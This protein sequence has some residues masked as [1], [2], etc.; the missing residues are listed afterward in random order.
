MSFCFM[1]FK[2]SF[3]SIQVNM[4]N[5]VKFVTGRYLPTGK[6]TRAL[7]SILPVLNNVT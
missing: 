4:S 7:C 5:N 6:E 3:D 1:F 2:K